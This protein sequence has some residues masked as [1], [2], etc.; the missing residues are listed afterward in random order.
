MTVY[1][2]ALYVKRLGDRIIT[3]YRQIYNARV[4]VGPDDGISI[5]DSWD[6]PSTE[7]AIAAAEA[8]DGEGD[9]PVGWHR[10]LKTG[11]R[12]PDGNALLEYIQ[13]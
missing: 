1:P 10:N 3:V 13:Y 7:Q 5:D 12:R 8:W 2:E 9:P 11:R 4:C 6:Y